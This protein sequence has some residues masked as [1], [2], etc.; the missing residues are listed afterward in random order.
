M[1]QIGAFH[2]KDFS[3]LWLLG[4]LISAGAVWLR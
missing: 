2:P 1:V 4:E 3:P